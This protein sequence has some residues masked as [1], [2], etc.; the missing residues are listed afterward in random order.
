MCFNINNTLLIDINHRTPATAQASSNIIRC[1][2]A[3]MSVAVLEDVIGGVGIGWTFTLLGFGVLLSG[4]LYWVDRRWGMKWRT[5]SQ[6]SVGAAAT[7]GAT[8]VE[9]E[10]Q[11]GV[12]RKGEGKKVE[13]S[14]I[15]ARMESESLAKA[16]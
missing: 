6:K 11:E 9:V 10:G 5:K 13:G 8:E 3:A 15:N 4:I 1:A 7:S 2:L 12:R 14:E 16:Q